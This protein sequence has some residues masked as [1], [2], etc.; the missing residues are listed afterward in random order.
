MAACMTR[1]YGIYVV[2]YSAMACTSLKHVY[3]G[4]IVAAVALAGAGLAHS[5]PIAA[6]TQPVGRIDT[7]LTDGDRTVMTS[8]W[9]PALE[10]GSRIPYIPASGPTA[11]ARIA[12]VSASWM[13]AP[14]AAIRMVGAK[15][16]AA[17]GAPV[18]GDHL[19]AVVVSPGMA[20]PRWIL[21]GLAADLAG[22]GYVVVVADHTGESPAVEFPTGGIVY[23]TPPTVTDEYM[24]QQLTTRIADMRLILDSLPTLPM[25]G[26]SIDL[27]RV[28]LA[29][30][31]YGGTTA[32][33]VMA[34]DPRVK[35]AVSVDGPAAWAHVA[36]VPTTDRPVLF[37]QLTDA[38]VQS[39]SEFRGE[40]FE[41]AI[42]ENAGHY[43]ATDMCQFDKSRE[44]C[45]TINPDDAARE[46]RTI[47]G[48]FLDHVMK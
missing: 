42:I 6:G 11:Q 35:A 19:P 39:W 12:S 37:L 34:K 13:H 4:L 26:P 27:E 20:T 38:W 21:S 24:G 3:T 7:P 1:Q 31:S 36:D 2:Q 18:A 10:T 17:E 41:H 25:V 40:G 46:S 8:V 44:L 9:Y 14:T 32:V 33:Q 15:I 28:A 45:G 5:S 43:S 23:G 48:S 22:R 47:I 30:H 16:P 29:G